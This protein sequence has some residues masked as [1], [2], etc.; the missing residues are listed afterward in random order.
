MRKMKP[1][2]T[3]GNIL[4]DIASIKQDLNSITNIRK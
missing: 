1:K 3:I 2:K 4:S